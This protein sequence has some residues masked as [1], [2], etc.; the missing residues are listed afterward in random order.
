MHKMKIGV[1]ADSFRLDTRQAVSKARELGVEG[2]QLYAVDGAMAPWNL[3][4]ARR[5]EL[6]DFIR[7]RGLAVSALCGD[8]GGYGFTCPAENPV[9]IERSK[10]IMDLAR[11]LECRIVTTHIGVIPAE[12]DHPRRAILRDACEKLG[13]YA[14][15]VG[16]IFAIETGPETARV[17]KDFLDSLTCHGVRVNLD[18]ANLLM[19]T[20]DDAAASVATL[21][22]AIVHT[23]A[24]D[25]ILL[26]IGRPEQFYTTFGEEAE[27]VDEAEYGIETPLG[28]GQVDFDRYLAALDEIGYDGFLTIE[29]E[30]GDFPERDIRLAV[31][32]LEGKLKQ[33]GRK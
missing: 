21:G 9:R 6:L 7:S 32:F 10:R 8:L 33:L 3:P 20:G 26:R 2:V 27:A 31:Q 16:A 14:D 18:P 13:S 12:P 5:R 24:K 28:E 23:H 29:R 19:V 22:G 1:L 30:V 15:Q 25:G 4:T 17:L 11:D